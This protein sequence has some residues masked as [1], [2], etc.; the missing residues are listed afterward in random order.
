MREQG[1][2]VVRGSI[3][4]FHR[5]EA[6]RYRRGRDSPLGYYED[7]FDHAAVR[8]A[9]LGVEGML[10]F[11][12]IFLLRP[13]LRDLWDFAVFVSVSFDEVIR[14]ALERD[15]P[16]LG[17]AEEVERRYR[18]RYIPGQ[19]LYFAESRPM[20]VADV[21]VENDDPAAPR[22]RGG[23]ADPPCRPRR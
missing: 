14:R 7:S 3:D 16:S 18:V 19:E 21:V 13:E 20:D 4:D 17:S 1:R 10:V 5:P 8:E 23:G 9:V 22:L 2:E 15:V 11:D 6:D 12:G